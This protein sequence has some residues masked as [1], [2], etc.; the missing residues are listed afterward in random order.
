M[1][2][3]FATFG[4]LVINLVLKNPFTGYDARTWLVFIATALVSHTIG[5]L[6]ISYALGHL[7]A[8]IVSPTLIAQP[9]LTTFLA[10][11]LLGEIPT[12]WQGLGGLLAMGGIYMINQSHHQLVR[13]TPNA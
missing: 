1:G 6:C 8:R 5:Y 3:V 13:G 12:L 4:M 7:P 2:G 10:V 11:P 9:I